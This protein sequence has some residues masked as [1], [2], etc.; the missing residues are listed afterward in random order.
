[1]IAAPAYVMSITE[2]AIVPQLRIFD[3]EAAASCLHRPFWPE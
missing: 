3:I 1:M 2:R